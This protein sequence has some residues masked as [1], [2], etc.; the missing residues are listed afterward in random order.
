MK[1]QVWEGSKIRNSLHRAWRTEGSVGSSLGLLC[2]IKILS[3]A[4]SETGC[5]LI[6]QAAC[7]ETSLLISSTLWRVC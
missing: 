7:W 2:N 3:S 5:F 6:S 4:A 1:V